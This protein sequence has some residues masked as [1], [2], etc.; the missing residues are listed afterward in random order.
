MN[1]IN[2]ATV[3][4]NLLVVLDAL[5]EAR[6]ATKAATRLGLT[7]SAVSNNLRRLR[8]LFEDPLMVRNAYGFVPTARAVALGPELR[9]LLGSARALIARPTVDP[10]HS[11]RVFTVAAVDAVGVV[12]LPHLLPLLRECMPR[13][14]LHLATLQRHIENDLACGD[15]DLLIGMPPQPPLGCEGEPVYEDRMVCCV[16]QGHPI[17]RRRLTLRQYAA[18]PHAE[19]AVLG[20]SDQRVDRALSRHN[21]SRTIAVTVSHFSNIPF[22][23]SSSD[24]IATVLR[25]LVASYIEP[26]QLRTL[27]PPL[28][29]PALTLH[30]YW[31]R[32]NSQDPELAQLRHLIRTAFAAASPS[33]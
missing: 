2:L 3:D 30:Q 21:L 29:L 6:S 18:L 8:E 28:D 13:A 31:H 19:V 26:L 33:H 15:V 14:R 12:L 5:L 22:V 10:A 4:L 20:E 1:D 32:R 9:A 17:G 24:L 23:V 27:R 7:Q 16:R 11:R 25:S